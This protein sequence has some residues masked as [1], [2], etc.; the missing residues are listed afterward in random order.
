[1]YG[2]K[3]CTIVHKN[4]LMNLCPRYKMYGECYDLYCDQFHPKIDCKFGLKC[5]RKEC[6]FRHPSAYYTKSKLSKIESV[7]KTNN[8]TTNKSLILNLEKTL[9]TNGYYSL[10]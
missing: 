2:N 8:N 10:F 1:M 3:T 6:S 5:N 7:N 9:S 4:H